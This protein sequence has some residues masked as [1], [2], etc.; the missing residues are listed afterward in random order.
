MSLLSTFVAPVLC[1]LAFSSFPSSFVLPLVRCVVLFCS[2]CWCFS[3]YASL[4]PTSVAPVLRL[5]AFSSFPSSFVLLPLSDWIFAISSVS[6]F[7]LF[8]VSYG[9][10]SFSFSF[11]SS[12][13]LS[14][15]FSSVSSVALSLSFSFVS[16]V[17]LSLSFSLVFALS[18]VSFSF[19]FNC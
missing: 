10:L 18:F 8:L 19:T 16:S 12:I 11:V 17:A 2:C 14:L 1:L 6:F 5:L 7:F 4:L 15:S 9:V 13:A 3:G